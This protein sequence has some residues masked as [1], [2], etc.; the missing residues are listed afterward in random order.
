MQITSDTIERA[1]LYLKDFVYH[2]NLNI[3][4]KSRVAAFECNDYEESIQNLVEI[5][6]APNFSLDSRFTNLYKKIDYHVIPKSVQKSEQSEAEQ[7]NRGLFLSNVTKSPAYEVPKTNYIIQAPIELHIIETL[8]CLIV[9]PLLDDRLSLSCY[10]NRISDSAKYFTRD[11]KAHRVNRNSS[12]IFK[13]YIDQYSIWRDGAIDC[14]AQLANSGRSVAIL[15][16][17]LKSYYYHIDIDFGGIESLL[18]DAYEDEES[19]NFAVEL[20]AALS[21]MYAQY[22]DAISDSLQSTHPECEPANCIP[23]GFSSS[24]ILANWYLRS[25]DSDV[26]TQVRPAYY[27]RYVDDILIVLENPKMESSSTVEMLM[28][29]YFS[30]LVSVGQAGY[31]Q[32]ELD[33]RILPINEEK[34][35]LHYFEAGSS[36]AGLNLL[37]KKLD[38]NSSA[39]NFLPNENIEEDLDLFAYDALYGNPKNEIGDILGFS[40]NSTGLARYLSSHIAAHRLCKLDNNDIVL[41]N[42]RKFFSGVNALEFFRLWEKVYQYGILTRQFK[43]VREFYS[44]INSAIEQIVPHKHISPFVIYSIQKDLRSYNNLSLSL[45]LA[46]LDSEIYEII[47]QEELTETTYSELMD[48]ELDAFSDPEDLTNIQR[49]CYFEDLSRAAKYFRMSNLIRH[50]LVA[51]PLV[52]YS[53]YTGDLTDEL[54]I[55]NENI[56][57]LNDLKVRLSPRFIHFDEWQIFHLK[58]S[59]NKGKS[60]ANW[61]KNTIIKYKKQSHWDDFPVEFRTKRN[62]KSS[63]N[64]SSLI[65]GDSVERESIRVALANMRIE[66]DSINSAVRPDKDPDLSLGRQKILFQLLN[67]AIRDDADILVMPEVSVPVSWLPFIISHARRHQIAIVFGLEH[68]TEKDIVY[69]LVIEALPFKVSGKYKSCLVTARIKNYY[70]PEERKLIEDVRLTPADTTLDF[71]EYHKVHWNGVCFASYNCFELSD[72]EHRTLFKSHIDIL[73]AC[74][75]NRDT[76]YYQHILE[77]SVRDLHCYVIQSNT[78]QYGGSCVLRPTKTESKTMLY[79]KGGINSCVLTTDLNIDSLRDFQFKTNP[80]PGD[81]YKQLPPGFDNNNVLDR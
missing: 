74:V 4:L 16:L 46:L 2:E 64:V 72:I 33:H 5:L 53:E 12:D 19:I 52:N 71:A 78:S 48:I 61:Q 15:T 6:N 76:N 35:V 20:T 8:W 68:W 81:E 24:A 77:S 63:L 40:G 18:Q 31:F 66:S 13:R 58:T 23:I 3:F 25:L 14:A 7:R 47:S 21:R 65:V 37:K 39:F 70:A 38:E 26:S 80:A 9:G 11:A 54:E 34:L 29:E 75:W 30:D 36:L 62:Q 67:D 44:M 43:F 73:I 27:G 69:N 55:G 49:L 51:W 22:S 56:A 60:L 45:G 17:D 59:I 32:L 42:L 28:N 1:Y 79:V 41:P 57:K 10:S 50:N